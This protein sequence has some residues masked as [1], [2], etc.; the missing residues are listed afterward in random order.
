MDGI[1]LEVIKLA[2]QI[3]TVVNIQSTIEKPFHINSIKRA[4]CDL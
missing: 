1:R 4:S 3:G 2:L